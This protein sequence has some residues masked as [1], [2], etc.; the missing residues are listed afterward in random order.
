VRANQHI[1]ATHFHTPAWH[2]NLPAIVPPFT[3]TILII[4]FC[5]QISLTRRLTRVT[6]AEQNDR[7]A[8]EFHGTLRPT[9]VPMARS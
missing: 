3:E 4:L 7:S 9:L 2:G 5:H 6:M 1:N 8:T